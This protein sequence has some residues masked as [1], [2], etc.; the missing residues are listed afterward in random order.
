MMLEKTIEKAVK[1]YVRSKG[2]LAYKWVSPGHI[3]VP[4]DILISPTGKV[5]FIEFKK[6]VSRRHRCRRGSIRGCV[7]TVPTCS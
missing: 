2:L 6:S 1:E 3:G 5:V 7:P 4:D